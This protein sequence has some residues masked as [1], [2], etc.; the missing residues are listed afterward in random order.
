MAK[1][2]AISYNGKR[3]VLEF[4]RT[5]VKRMEG[6]GFRIMDID[7][8]PMTMFT[9]LFNGAFEAN[10]SAVK[11]TTREKIYDSLKNRKKLVQTLMEMYVDTYNT[12]FDDEEEAADEGNP[13]WEVTE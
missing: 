7:E 9:A 13:G 10:H 1:K 4:T 2:I 5:V 12:L 11:G 3:Y 6:Q 8:M